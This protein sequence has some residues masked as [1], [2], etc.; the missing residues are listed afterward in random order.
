MSQREEDILYQALSGVQKERF[1]YLVNWLSWLLCYY[2]EPKWYGYKERSQNYFHSELSSPWLVLK[3]LP[4]ED[5][6]YL[7][8]ALLFLLMEIYIACCMY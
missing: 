8:I 6:K 7:A 5:L 4:N 1:C 2:K 3:Y